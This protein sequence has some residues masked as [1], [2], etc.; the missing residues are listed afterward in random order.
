MLIPRLAACLFTALVSVLLAD[1]LEEKS[2]G[3]ELAEN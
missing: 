3:N 1:I 2:S